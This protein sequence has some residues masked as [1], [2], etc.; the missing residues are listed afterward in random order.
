MTILIAPILSGTLVATSARA[1]ASA[2]L[3]PLLQ[4]ALSS[5]APTA[6]LVVIAELDHVARSS[7]LAAIQVLGATP[8]GFRVLPMVAIE[9]TPAEIQAVANLSGVTSL[10]LNHP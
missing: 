1:A 5:A 7:D 4:R 8:V 9:G 3:D 10:W 6:T 2:S